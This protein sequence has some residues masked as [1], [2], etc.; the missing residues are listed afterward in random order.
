MEFNIIE[1]GG[2]CTPLGF[3]AAS[4]VADIKGK[5][6]GNTDLAV[7]VSDAIC[8]TAAVF[9]TNIVTAAP[10]QY[11]KALLAKGREFMGIVVNSGN[12]NACTGKQG[13]IDCEAISAAVE[14]ELE[15]PKG[16]ILAAST[17]VIG[18]RLPAD[19]IIAHIPAL[20]EEIDDDGGSAFAKAIMTTDTVSKE[21]ALLVETDKGSFVIGGTCKGAGMMSPSMATMLA[22]VTTDADIS[23]DRLQK[24]LNVASEASFNSINVDGDMSTNDTLLAFANGMSDVAIDDSNSALFQEALNYLCKELALMI[25]RDA[26]GASK[27]VTI[28]VKGAK[29]DADAK[30]CAMKLSNSPLVKTM[31]AGSDPNWG[32]LMCTAGYSGAQFDPEKVSIWFN[33]LHY[34]KDSTLIDPA[35]EDKAYAI[36]KEP[37]FTIT[38]DLGAGDGVG[39]YYTCDLTKEY[40]AINADYRS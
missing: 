14:N 19:K 7:L 26:E 9:T 37:E 4:C 31:F 23:A 8:Q 39:T 22:F 27:M 20:C 40:V 29:S 10:V 38:L 11:D 3:A 30:L 24:M 1:N 16:S 25:V 2:V 5:G 13:F 36:M 28:M 32:R 17:G 6:K 15:L 18:N 12:A 34:V 33:D 35:L 21:L